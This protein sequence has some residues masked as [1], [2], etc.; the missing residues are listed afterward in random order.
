MWFMPTARQL[1]S[2]CGGCAAAANL[3]RERTSCRRVSLPHSKIG[4]HRFYGLYHEIFTTRSFR[5]T[6][7][8]I[9]EVRLRFPGFGA[10]RTNTEGVRH[11]IEEHQARVYACPQQ[12]PMKI[13]SAA[14]TVIACRS[15]A[16]SRGNP[17]RSA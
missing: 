9:E 11:G 17:F 12:C 8:T 4:Q 3:A 5:S 15:H 14:Q 7:M 1:L 2:C 6:Q 16:E 13:D 10:G